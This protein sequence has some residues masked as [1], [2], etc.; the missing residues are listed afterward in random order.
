MQKHS[1]EVQNRLEL[2]VNW[3]RFLLIYYEKRKLKFLKFCFKNHR[4][5]SSQ[6][7]LFWIVSKLEVQIQIFKLSINRKFIS[8][9]KQSQ[10]FR[11][12]LQLTVYNDFTHRSI[13]PRQSIWW[14]WIQCPMLDW[15]IPLHADRPTKNARRQLTF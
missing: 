4:H 13:F 3:A 1:G 15:N 12:N 8:K 5:M 11:G 7:N 9:S 2:L 6:L 10:F 14:H